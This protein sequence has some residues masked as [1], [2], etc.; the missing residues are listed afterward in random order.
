[1]LISDLINFMGCS[2]LALWK[3]QILRAFVGT[4]SFGLVGMV[5]EGQC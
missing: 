3:F 1:M 5:N 4:G 2:Q